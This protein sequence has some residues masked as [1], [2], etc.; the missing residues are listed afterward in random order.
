MSNYEHND[1]K[2]PAEGSIK[3]S[4]PRF[5]VALLCMWDTEFLPRKIAVTSVM[6]K[7]S[8]TVPGDYDTYRIQRRNRSGSS[9]V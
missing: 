5:Q 2:Q 6:A 1:E 3:F 4:D 9:D 8:Q 7:L